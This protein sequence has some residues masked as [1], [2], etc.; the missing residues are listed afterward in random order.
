VGDLVVDRGRRISGRVVD[1]DGRQ[2][3]DAKVIYG[4]SLD[5]D[6]SRIRVSGRFP[7]SEVS[8]ISGPDGR[9]VLEGVGSDRGLVIADPERLG[10]SRAVVIPKGTQDSE[11]VLV[12]HETGSIRGQVRVNGK[13]EA[14]GFVTVHPKDLQP[15]QQELQVSTDA[16]GKYVIERVTSGELV[17]RAR[18]RLDTGGSPRKRKVVVVKPGEQIVVDF[19][20]K[21][22][23]ISLGVN[24][25]GKKGARVE[26][27]N[28]WLF[29]GRVE[30]ST[31]G[32]IERLERDPSVVFHPYYFRCTPENPCVFKSVL[33]GEHTLCA[34]P[35]RSLE[36]KEYL[37]LVHKHSANMPVICRSI[38]IAAEPKEQTLTLYLRATE[39]PAEQK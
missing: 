32:D 38:Q 1:G 18:S 2:V 24:V 34:F 17:M 19:D 25:R 7:T 22:S 31:R 20:L 14:L 28:I 4:T 15:V 23:E 35:Y 30:A 6:G 11:A 37:K 9:F 5:G 12:V 29:R 13:P 36:N 26:H 10:R 39:P 21:R 33:P 27:A 8:G 16:D 3:A